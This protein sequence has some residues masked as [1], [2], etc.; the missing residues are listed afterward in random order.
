M[1][2]EKTEV[3]RLALGKSLDGVGRRVMSTPHLPTRYYYSLSEAAEELGCRESDILHWGATGQMEIAIRLPLFQ[4]NSETYPATKVSYTFKY[5]RNDEGI[6]QH[7]EHFPDI[8]CLACIYSYDISALEVLDS[9]DVHNSY[10]LYEFSNHRGLTALTVDDIV[11]NHFNPDKKK[12]RFND[13]GINTSTDKLIYSNPFFEIFLNDDY[14]ESYNTSNDWIKI[15]KYDLYVLSNEIKRV[16]N[17][18]GVTPEQS[19]IMMFDC[20]RPKTVSLQ[21]RENLMRQIR[22]NGLNPLELTEG[23]GGK[24]GSK[25]QLKSILVTDTM[26]DSQFEKTWE[27]AMRDKVI[28]YKK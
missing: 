25:S 26:T 4:D 17:N 1:Q 8:I 15:N 24:A 13:I 27:S 11:Q 22:A 19:R 12:Q 3:H 23:K 2:R 5:Q 21:H 16:K 10:K 9:I 14:C 6:Y 28:Q 18:T 7:A 20:S